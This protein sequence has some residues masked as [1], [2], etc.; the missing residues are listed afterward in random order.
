VRFGPGAGGVKGEGDDGGPDDERPG[1]HP[2]EEV[3]DARGLAPRR[4]ER[5]LD[6]AATG[7]QQKRAHARGPPNRAARHA[8]G[9][10]AEQ[11][12]RLMSTP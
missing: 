4:V 10:V 5:R 1:G 6:A 12:T 7:R 2:P 11:S 3:G 9:G 8:H